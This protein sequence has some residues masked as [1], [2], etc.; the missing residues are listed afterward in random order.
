MKARFIR[1]SEDPLLAKEQIFDD[2][3]DP[4][5]YIGKIGTVE[6]VSKSEE[7]G[8]WVVTFDDGK[9]GSFHESELEFIHHW[10]G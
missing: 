7:T 3:T 4:D 10:G 9:T 1:T 5:P 2:G 8:M 6:P